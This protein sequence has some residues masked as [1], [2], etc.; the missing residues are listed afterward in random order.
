M[1]CEYSDTVYGPVYLIY[2]GILYS[3]KRKRVIWERRQ[4]D[5]DISN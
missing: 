5:I 2:L 4:H 1:I 3:I